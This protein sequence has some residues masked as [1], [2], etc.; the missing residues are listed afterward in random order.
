[1]SQQTTEVDMSEKVTLSVHK[2]SP[3]I[4]A[5]G[6]ES[7]ELANWLIGKANAIRYAIKRE[8]DIREYQLRL[9]ELQHSEVLFTSYV[10][11]GL[12]Q[13]ETDPI[14]PLS[15]EAIQFDMRTVGFSS[16]QTKCA[17]D[18]VFPPIGYSHLPDLGEE[19]EEFHQR[20]VEQSALESS[21]SGHAVDE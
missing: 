21:Q 20:K 19:R 6:L 9:S 14:P 11:L 1:M 5:G 17:A 15:A 12:S 2:N 10:N 7:E 13:K 16:F 4:W 18:S 8:R 3:H